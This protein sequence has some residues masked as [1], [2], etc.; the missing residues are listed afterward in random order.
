MYERSRVHCE[1]KVQPRSTFTFTRDLSYIAFILFT[2][3]NFT[4]P[5]TRGICTIART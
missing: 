3:V 1:L 5:R 4:R 2:H